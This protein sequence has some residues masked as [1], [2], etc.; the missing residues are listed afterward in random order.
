MLMSLCSRLFFADRRSDRL[1]RAL[2][3]APSTSIACAAKVG[4][5]VGSKVTFQKSALAGSR[6]SARS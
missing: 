1:S 4:A 3:T 5:S 2:R 6:I